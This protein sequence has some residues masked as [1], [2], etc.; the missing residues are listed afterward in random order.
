ML[1]LVDEAS[2]TSCNYFLEFIPFWMN[3]TKKKKVM[4]FYG[5]QQ[6]LNVLRNEQTA[7][8]FLPAVVSYIHVAKYRHR[9]YWGHSL[10]PHQW[11]PNNRQNSCSIL[12][13]F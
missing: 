8:V 1:V 10:P 2:F 6:A 7:C 13:F 5:R 12:F 11:W 3:S 4:Y 9:F